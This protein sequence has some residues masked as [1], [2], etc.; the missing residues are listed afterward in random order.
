M[1]GRK[2]VCQAI[3]IC[4]T[5]F[6]MEK[7]GFRVQ[8]RA[9]RVSFTALLLYLRLRARC[10]ARCSWRLFPLSPSRTLPPLQQMQDRL[11]RSTEVLKEHALWRAKHAMHKFVCARKMLFIEESKASRSLGAHQKIYV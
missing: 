7:Y 6:L 4:L 11:P 8:L 9:F 10:H 2:L 3:I 5:W 1:A